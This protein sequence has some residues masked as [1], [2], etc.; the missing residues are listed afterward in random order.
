MEDLV[1]SEDPLHRAVPER[2]LP[3]DGTGISW[4]LLAADSF[5]ETGT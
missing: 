5:I 2:L 1:A 4:L 3:E